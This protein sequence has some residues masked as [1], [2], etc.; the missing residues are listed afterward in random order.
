MSGENNNIQ[1]LDLSYLNKNHQ[2]I[3]LGNFLEK[4][5]PYVTVDIPFIIDIPNII[6][7]RPEQ[8][9]L[10]PPSLIKKYLDESK[11]S[12]VMIVTSNI[13]KSFPTLPYLDILRHPKLIGVVTHNPS[14]MH[15][16]IF[17]LP[18]GP[19]WQMKSTLPF[20]ESKIAKR[21]LYLDNC[22]SNYQSAYEL[23]KKPRKSLAWVR[24]MTQSVGISRNYNCHFSKALLYNRN[25]IVNVL[26][27]VSRIE[28]AKNMISTDK[29]LQTLQQYRFVISPHGNGLDA[30][31]TWEALMCGCIPIVP[32]SPLN[33]IYKLL[34]VW[35]VQDWNEIT[36]EKIL[37]KEKE[38]LKKIK[39]NDFELI[40]ESGIKKYIQNIFLN[41]IHQS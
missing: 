8:T 25:Q 39:A 10:P 4:G 32:S 22:A 37:E 16:K 35:V 17:S 6:H 23:F 38:Y 19:K 27:E 40:F 11:D 7:Y 9:N 13:D 28:I 18:L 20:G 24:P 30:H 21:N 3:E 2:L 31:S 12:K 36:N 14:F 41:N 29:Y 26:Q 1:N 33:Q 34:P 15:P 5:T